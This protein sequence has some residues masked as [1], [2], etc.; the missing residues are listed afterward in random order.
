MKK[1]NGFQQRKKSA[2]LWLIVVLMFAW[3]F[4]L[5]GGC[6]MI[7]ILNAPEQINI[8][9]L[10]VTHDETI[11]QSR[12]VFLKAILQQRHDFRLLSL[13]RGYANK[14]LLS[15]SIDFATMG[16]TN[17]VIALA[18]GIKVELVWIHEVL[19]KAEQL[20]VRQNSGIERIEDLA[21]RQVATVFASTAHYSLLNALRDAGIED[22]VTLLDM[23]TADIVAAWERGDIDAA[24]TWQPTLDRLLAEG[25]SL[26]SSE[27]MAERG[28][29]TA[30]VLLAR[31]GFSQKYPILMADFISALAKAGDLYRADPEKAAQIAGDELEIPTTVAS[32]Q[33][34]GSLWL[35]REEAL[36]EAFMGTSA[37]PGHF[38][39]VMHDTA[40]FLA[41]QQSIQSIPTYEDFAAF[42][43][44][45]WIEQSLQSEQN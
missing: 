19:G 29:V 40:A 7:T 6:G 9:Y 23:Q 17:A 42:V 43:N 27:E 5:P 2:R 26:V 25:L 21:G 31:Q 20:V 14:A 10:R 30:N 38:V 39:Q 37:D 36:S 16:H 28:V 13:I 15:N 22:Q 33:M 24:Y 4:S 1:N 35:T 12:T 32:E 11:A 45:E 8:G 34:S 3:S 44:P 18:T 41:E